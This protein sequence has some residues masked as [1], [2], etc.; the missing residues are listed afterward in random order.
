MQITFYFD[1]IS[2]GWK[3]D[4]S[5][6]SQCRWSEL[7][8]HAMNW[9]PLTPILPVMLCTSSRQQIKVER[10]HLMKLH[11]VCNRCQHK[12]SILREGKWGEVWG[13]CSM[14]RVESGRK[15]QWAHNYRE[16]ENSNEKRGKRC[17]K[18]QKQRAQI[19]WLINT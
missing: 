19:V 18:R 14:N 2:G 12:V 8:H 1:S 6:C 16:E 10:A 3:S 15:T 5:S 11:L 7:G 4:Y 9:L 13:S 17:G